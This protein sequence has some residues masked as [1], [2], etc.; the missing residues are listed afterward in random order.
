MSYSVTD[1]DHAALPVDGEETGAALQFDDAG[2]EVVA[3]DLEPEP[4]HRGESV[5][6]FLSDLLRSQIV[7][8]G[9]GTILVSPLT[10][11]VSKQRITF[12]SLM[13]QDRLAGGWDC[14]EVQSA[15]RVSPI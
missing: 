10:L 15:S 3:R 7:I 9:L 4:Q 8:S 6:I 14:Q 1:T 5:V 12:S 11:S 13:N 2:L